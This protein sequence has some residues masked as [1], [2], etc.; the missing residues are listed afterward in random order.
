MEYAQVFAPDDH[1]AVRFSRELDARNRGNRQ[2]DLRESDGHL[3]RLARSVRPTAVEIFRTRWNVGTEHQPKGREEQRA[4]DRMGARGRGVL[5][6]LVLRLVDDVVTHL[7]DH[8]HEGLAGHEGRLELRWTSQRGHAVS[9]ALRAGHSGRLGDAVA[10]LHQKMPHVDGLIDR[11]DRRLHEELE[12]F[13]EVDAGRR[14]C[15]GGEGDHALKGLSG[16]STRELLKVFG[17]N[18]SGA[19]RVEFDERAARRA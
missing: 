2:I 15:V 10:L 14:L 8:V 4:L 6:L 12:E 17:A 5:R 9:R 18:V 19:A 1:S 16:E 11:V 7:L 3:V 13:A